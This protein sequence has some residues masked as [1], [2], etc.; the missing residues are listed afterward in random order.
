MPNHFAF[1]SRSCVARECEPQPARQHAAILHRD[2]RPGRGQIV[3]DAL[4]RRKAAVEGDPSGLLH[5]FARCSLLGCG[6]FLL[7][8]ENVPGPPYPT[9][10]L[11]N[12]CDPVNVDGAG[13][14]GIASFA[15]RT[16]LR[17]ACPGAQTPLYVRAP[18]IGRATT[19]PRWH[20]ASAAPKALIC[21][22]Y[23]F[24]SSSWGPKRSGD[25]AAGT[26]AAKQTFRSLRLSVRTPPFHGGESG[27]I[28]LGS[29]IGSN[30][31]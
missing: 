29:A 27:S 11:K 2:L 18:L 26:V 9:G 13:V 17:A 31:P 20:G 30:G 7:S 5:R 8:V 16:G 1:P 10:A 15:G 19:A 12:R 21:R 22:A 24:V 25:A 23:F 6:H 14:A 3:H 28:P 4:A